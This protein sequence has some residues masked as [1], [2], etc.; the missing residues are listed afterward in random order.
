MSN[1]Q[2]ILDANRVYASNFGDKGK[3]P[4]PPA[5]RFAI[6]T[7]M[8][9]RIDPAKLAGL[10][11][12]D[13]H[14]IRNAGGRA[15]DDAIRSLVISY[16]LL[17]TREW[18]VIH[19]THC[20][21]ETFTDETIRDLLANSLETA[22]HDGTGW[23]DVGKGPGSRQ[24]DYIDWLTI[25]DQAQ[26]VVTD[27]ERIRNHPLVPN[28]IPIFGYIYQVESGK[29]VEVPEATAVGRAAP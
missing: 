14:V 28:S 24:G 19:H 10:S 27:V 29:L 8:D 2:A 5:R 17:G 3:L 21:M 11:E 7:C 16:K 6:L 18:Y 9:A 20:G 1:Q 12:G 15:S 25:R 13:A 26:S 4:I 22:V 23:K